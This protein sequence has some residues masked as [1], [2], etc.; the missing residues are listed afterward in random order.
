MGASRWLC[1]LAL[2]CSAS[3]AVGDGGAAGLVGWRAARWGMTVAEVV[4]AF[5]GEATRLTPEEK[6]ADGKVVA[7][8]IDGYTMASQAFRVRFL[9]DRGK[10]ALVS[11]RTPQEKYADAAAYEQF[12]K[13]LGEEL[14]GPGEATRDDNFVDLRQ[15]RWKGPGTTVD[16]KFIPGVVVIQYYPTRAA[17]M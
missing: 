16:L 13:Y 2:A 3:T 1:A 15:T 9:F 7:A 5:P 17:T 14:G 8:G 6:L 11:L 12:R 10:L 4:A